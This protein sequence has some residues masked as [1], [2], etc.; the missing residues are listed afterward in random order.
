MDNVEIRI[1][2]IVISPI[3]G[4]DKNCDIYDLGLGSTVLF[5]Y[6]FC[7]ADESEFLVTA[8]CSLRVVPSFDCMASVF[9]RTCR[10]I[11][12]FWPICEPSVKM[13]VSRFV[14]ARDVCALRHSQREGNNSLTD[15]VN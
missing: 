5:C 2:F 8:T 15:N 1:I 11:T 13:F 14:Y 10:V 4:D 9:V 7:A 6:G 3:T 12:A